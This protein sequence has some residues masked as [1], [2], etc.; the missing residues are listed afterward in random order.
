MD[1]EPQNPRGDPSAGPSGEM[2][3][4]SGDPRSAGPTEEMRQPSGDPR[5]EPT[6]DERVDAAIAGLSA[7][8]DME[9]AGRPAV[10]EAVHDRLREILGELGDAGRPGHGAGGD[11]RLGHGAAGDPRP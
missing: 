11:P 10:L 8:D 5:A 7:L 1:P 6:G 4:P 2:R 9:L 3:E